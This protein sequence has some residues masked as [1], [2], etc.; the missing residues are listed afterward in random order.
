MNKPV[1]QST[2]SRLDEPDAI[3]SDDIEHRLSDYLS[4]EE[5]DLSLV[6]EILSLSYQG[7][8]DA[9][10]TLMNWA[11]AFSCDP[12][13]L[14]LEATET[15]ALN[16]EPK[17]I[18]RID[19]ALSRSDYFIP[20]VSALC[21]SVRWKLFFDAMAER[22]PTSILTSALKREH[23]LI[24]AGVNR[25]FLDSPEAFCIEFSQML[26]TFVSGEAT[27]RNNTTTAEFFKKASVLCGYNES[28]TKISLGILANLSREA[29]S[30]AT[31]L[32]YRRLAYHI[33]QEAISS[34][35]EIGSLSKGRH[36]IR[37]VQ[38]KSRESA[39]MHVSKLMVIAD[40]TAI[41]TSIR[42]KLIDAILMVILST[43]DVG[44]N[45]NV[46]KMDE[47]VN[48][49]THVFALL[50]GQM[51][52]GGATIGDKMQLPADVRLNPITF[53]EKAVL[54]RM[55][56]HKEVLDELLMA[57][58]S[59]MRRPEPE[60]NL[61]AAK[62]R[63][64]C[65]LLAFAATFVEMEESTVVEKLREPVECQKM[66]SV[67]SQM[68]QKLEVVVSTCENLKPGTA[69]FILMK[70]ID[71]LVSAARDRFA[72]RGILIWA[73]EC[74][75]GGSNLRELRVTSPLHLSFLAMAA[76][77]HMALRPAVV[78]TICEAMIRDYPDLVSTDVADLQSRFISCLLSFLRFNMGF[79][80]ADAFVKKLVD[81]KCVDLSHI[82]RF[83]YE[84]LRCVT[85]PFSKE[86][87]TSMIRLIG[88]PR[89][90]SAIKEGELAKVVTKFRNQV[91]QDVVL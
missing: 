29:H 65:I 46:R 91:D 8:P 48:M 4:K 44:A 67:V 76:D 34:I 59:T 20:E 30:P 31:R 51:M 40:C 11:S 26:T 69:R 15:A 57:A 81:A 37:T 89:L 22:H 39:M 33:R 12:D 14:L 18:P 53:Q 74:L 63:C 41:D 50:I 79:L 5:S 19:I 88:H 90:A 80:I 3:L 25:A 24:A 64:L 7:I 45:R 27:L 17:F 87:S 32:F 47:E 43:K 23:Q 66:C 9:I 52:A 62:K 58:F 36:A 55:L 78:D 71:T 28:V 85:T 84:T 70:S 73:R 10:R 60:A 75:K 54:I 35:L 1:I 2:L 6:G 77:K 42:T 13:A 38:E 16:L 21:T 83:V 61:N 72:S 49:V 68:F 86:F 82:R 56:C